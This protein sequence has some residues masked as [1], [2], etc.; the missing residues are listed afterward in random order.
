MP[1]ASDMDLDSDQGLVAFMVYLI[2]AVAE[3][4]WDSACNWN[5]V[6]D[7]CV[8]TGQQ[9]RVVEL[10]FMRDNNWNVLISA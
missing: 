1:K 3:T 2:T 9:G 4:W 6:M 10:L 5:A 7:G 8:Q